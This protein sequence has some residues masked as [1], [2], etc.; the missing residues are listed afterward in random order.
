MYTDAHIYMKWRTSIHMIY[1]YISCVYRKTSLKADREV[2]GGGGG[3]F[4]VDVTSN[5]TLISL[6]VHFDSTSISLCFHFNFTLISLRFHFDV[7]SM[8]LRFHLDSTSIS[9]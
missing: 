3:G 7:T 4:H 9:L 6:R 8:P 1:I 5:F 2:C